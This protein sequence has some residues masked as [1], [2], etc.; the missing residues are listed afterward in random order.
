MLERI[1]KIPEIK[2]ANSDQQVHG[3]QTT[4]EV[5]RDT[6]SR[7]GV[8]MAAIDSTLN[9]A[10]GQ[11]QVSNI[12]KGLNQYHVVLEVAA[13]FRQDPKA[14]DN[15]Y[16]QSSTTGTLIPLSTFTHVVPTQ[17]SLTVNH[18]GQFPSITLSFNLAPGASLGKAVTDI[19][20]AQR[21]I[22][23]PANVHA[24]PSGTAQAFQA[25]LATMP[26]L[27]LTAIGA[28]YIVLGILYES[29]IH[30]ITILS[31][32]PSAG[33]GALLAIFLFK[34]DLNIIAD[35]GIILLIGIVKKNA[36]LMIDFALQAE[37]IDG[38]SPLDAIHQACVLRFR[39][40]MMT[41]M[42]ALLGAVPLA[43]G[44]GT[45]SELRQPLGITIVGGLIVSQ[46]LTLF[47][48]P[49]VYLYMDRLQTWVRGSRPV[50]Q[51]LPKPAPAD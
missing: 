44:G 3:L 31:T 41:T 21:E 38:K 35:I 49:V 10:F 32:I 25:S 15:I 16:I 39:P 42:A 47:T 50:P 26:M 51:Q 34:S 45:G 12:Y 29:Y 24:S 30:P 43:I 8:P 48:T 1:S 22:G 18:Q 14:L 46:M 4:I 7:L 40:I 20:A 37:R 5:D 28:V 27:I 33:I 36:I 17:L 23:L 11:R 6:A 2:D 19:Q 9:D 13:D